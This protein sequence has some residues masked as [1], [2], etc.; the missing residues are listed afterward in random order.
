MN[1]TLF[2][3]HNTE[4]AATDQ[5]DDRKES[6]KLCLS[7]LKYTLT[8]VLVPIFDI[9][10]DF[11]TA[12]THFWWGNNSWGILT[13]FFIALPG[14]V[15]G[16]AIAIFGLRKRFTLQRLLNYSVI[17]LL[18]PI[19]YPI[20][21]ICVNLY[22]VFLIIVQKSRAVV[23]VMGHD[24]K[25][26]KSLEGFLESGPQFVLQSYILLRGEDVDVD[27]I[28]GGEQIIQLCR[29]VPCRLCL[30]ANKTIFRVAYV[31]DNE[32]VFL[33]C[34]LHNGIC[35]RSSTVDKF[36]YPRFICFK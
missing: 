21:S 6:I 25:Q 2:K 35:W 23:S 13:L 18:A 34:D 17:A 32:F 20:V 5:T 3:G 16:S 36:K 9:G 33:L 26:F 28:T 4:D 22:M 24:V 8:G 1:T 7:V 10:S 30:P 12:I 14:I 19:L 31:A 27:D 11:V 29:H 15:C